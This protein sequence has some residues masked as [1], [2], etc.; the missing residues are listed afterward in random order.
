MTD[1][2]S[3]ETMRYKYEKRDNENLIRMEK[4]IIFIYN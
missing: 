4:N 3:F 1:T 2:K